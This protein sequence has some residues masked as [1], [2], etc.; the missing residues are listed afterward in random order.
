MQFSQL[1]IYKVVF[2]FEVIKWVRWKFSFLFKNF[3]CPDATGLQ[4]YTNIQY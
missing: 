4:E 2:F 1:Y 3:L